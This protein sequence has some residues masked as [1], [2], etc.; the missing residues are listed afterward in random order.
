MSM[1]FG[2]LNFAVG[3]N[4]TSAFPLDANS[5]FET[6]DD[7]V[8]AAA[9]AAEVGSADSAYYIGQLLIVKDATVGVGLY[10]INAG[11]TLTK[12]GQASSADELAE[13]VSA[14]EARC[15]T[16]EGKLILATS[17]KD[18]LMSSVDKAKLDALETNYVQKDGDKVLSDN[19]YSAADKAIVD[20][21]EGKLETEKQRAM[22]AEKENK[23]AI[24]ADVKNLADNYY[25]K[26]QV[27][28]KIAGKKTAY[29]Y[30][31]KADETYLADLKTQGKFN[32][33]D[34]IYFKAKKVSD[35]WV[36]AILAEADASGYFY[37][38]SD[39]EVDHPSL[40]GYATKDEVSAVSTALDKETTR[41]TGVE[42]EI[43][44]SL[45]EKATTEALN[46][47]SADV[48][49][50]KAD[51]LKSSDKT[52]LTTA[53]GKKADQTALDT[54]NA[55]IEGLQTS[56]GSAA[57]EAAADGSL[58]ARIANEV[59][60]RTS[61]DASLLKKITANETAITGLRGDLGLKE[62]TSDKE[63][64]FGKIAKLTEDI[65]AAGKIDSVKVNGVA[66]PIENKA[67]D[68]TIPDAL[69]KSVE[70]TQLS[71]S[72]QGKLGI[73]AVNVNLLEQTEGDTLVLQCG[74][75][76]K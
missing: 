56:V 26:T 16:I 17:E 15:T 73:K 44:T 3:F 37:E 7:A 34:N 5:Y 10:Q 74:T 46:A 33:G 49:A 20:G 12:F 4:R 75:A 72:E 24:A 42:N 21:I 18:G 59:A 35:Q 19:N 48:A 69:V 2:K 25:N 64:I 53:I 11:K 45:L 52:E 71:V 55:A 28:E 57:D 30:Q 27:E 76:T 31:D 63:T 29:V 38:L 51:Y 70:A 23:D 8:T 1:E 61:E 67:V 41:A 40:E 60:T 47:V 32:L 14:L 50:I 9:G 68:I 66:L 22:A 62:D 6:Y 36:S 13:K 58:Y 43:K 54:A 65:A 39:L